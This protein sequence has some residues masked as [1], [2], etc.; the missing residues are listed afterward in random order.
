MDFDLAGLEPSVVRRLNGNDTGNGTTG[1]G[2]GGN[3]NTTTTTT[4][5]VS[6][7]PY[8]G[9]PDCT[10]TTTTT[11]TTTEAAAGNGTESSGN[12]T[13]GNSTADR[14]LSG[15]SEYMVASNQV[16]GSQ[17]TAA[18]VPMIGDLSLS[19]KKSASSWNAQH[20]PSAV[21]A[22]TLLIDSTSAQGR[23]LQ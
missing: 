19:G 16:I 17:Y 18:K 9:L 6:R 22:D 21:P 8:E 13:S 7:D 4:T 10:T 15:L 23:E 1:N 20:V 5:T 3:E 14:R 2:T 11:S 12:S